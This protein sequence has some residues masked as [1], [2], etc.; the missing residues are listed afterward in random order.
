MLQLRAVAESSSGTDVFPLCSQPLFLCAPGAAA[1]SVPGS[2]RAPARHEEP[3]CGHS[4]ALLGLAV[5]AKHSPQ[6]VQPQSHRSHPSLPG[7]AVSPRA[8]QLLPSSKHFPSHPHC[9]ARAGDQRGE[10]GQQL[11]GDALLCLQRRA[12][13]ARGQGGKG[14][15]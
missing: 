7:R 9:G 8:P 13:L 1:A 12:A 15:A 4:W 10:T 3:G 6:P 2:P 5:D 11:I 14:K